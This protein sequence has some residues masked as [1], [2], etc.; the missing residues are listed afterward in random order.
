MKHKYIS[1]FLGL[2]VALLVALLLIFFALHRNKNRSPFGGFP[3]DRIYLGFMNIEDP[4]VVL[5]DSVYYVATKQVLFDAEDIP[6]PVEETMGMYRIGIGV[7]ILSHYDNTD[8]N[9]VPGYSRSQLGSL[10]ER[11]AF[12]IMKSA[13]V[14]E[15][16][17]DDYEIYRFKNNPETFL[18]ELVT[19]DIAIPPK[20]LLTEKEITGIEGDTEWSIYK[21]NFY[22]ILLVP[23]FKKQYLQELEIDRTQDYGEVF[24]WYSYNND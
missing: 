14:F 23:I 21:S 16:E 7:R 20:R 19:D 12:I 4:I 10:I 2:S 24:D 18:I 13:I 8:L 5:K 9:L 11:N 22:R 17:K 3:P 6:F 1:A 15:E